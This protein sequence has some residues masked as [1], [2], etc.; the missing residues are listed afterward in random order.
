MKTPNKI[1]VLSAS[2]LAGAGVQAQTIAKPTTTPPAGETVVLSPFEVS[3]STDTGYAAKE[4]LA[5]TRMRTDLKDV[6]AALTI[7][8]PQ[9]MQDLAVNT[10]DQALLYTLVRSD[11]DTN[12][13]YGTA[14]TIVPVLW[15]LR[16]PRNFVLTTT[17][18]F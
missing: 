18:D 1:A 15:Q 14:N 4:T 17:F 2:L 3:S 12:G 16:R 7:L 10:F 6:G 8:T 9:F 13:I 11:Y 5:G